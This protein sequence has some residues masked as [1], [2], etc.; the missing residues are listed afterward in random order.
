MENIYNYGETN[1]KHR[2]DVIIEGDFSL[3]GIFRD[4]LSPRVS[5]AG[6]YEILLVCA[7]NFDFAQVV[8]QSTRHGKTVDST[9][10]FVF[11]NKELL[12]FGVSVV[13]RRAIRS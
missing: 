2:Q 13:I 7:F 4:E 10:E 11:A 9:L 6:P 5:D 1:I 8:G 3:P 12:N